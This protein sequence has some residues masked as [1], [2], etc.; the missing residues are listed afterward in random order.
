MCVRIGGKS[1]RENKRIRRAYN[2]YSGFYM[3]WVRVVSRG[4]LARICIQPLT[5][6]VRA[7]GEG[8]RTGYKICHIKGHFWPFW[9]TFTSKITYQLQVIS[10]SFFEGIIPSNT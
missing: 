5:G 3:A 2:G 6:E 9:L 4:L 1:K 7:V 8:S 10:V